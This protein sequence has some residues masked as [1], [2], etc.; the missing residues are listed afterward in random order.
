MS[1]C[2]SMVISTLVTY[3]HARPLIL[4]LHLFMKSHPVQPSPGPV[5]KKEADMWFDTMV[6]GEHSSPQAHHLTVVHL[7]LQEN[8]QYSSNY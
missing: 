7:D 4:S 3:V 2:M 1:H 6:S 5:D 8:R